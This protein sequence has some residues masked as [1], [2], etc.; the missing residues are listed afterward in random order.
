MHGFAKASKYSWDSSVIT[1]T[2]KCK[3]L[4]HLPVLPSLSLFPKFI[5][6]APPPKSYLPHL[7]ELWFQMLYLHHCRYLTNT[8]MPVRYHLISS[9]WAQLSAFR[10]SYRI[11]TK[12]NQPVS[13]AITLQ[14]KLIQIQEAETWSVWSKSVQF[15]LCRMCNVTNSEQMIILFL[16]SG[17]QHLALITQR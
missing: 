3:H 2:S 9:G 12:L 1:I 10:R 16:E 15:G 11:I 6:H 4:S 8:I 14:F 7:Y 13:S 17:F 5:Q